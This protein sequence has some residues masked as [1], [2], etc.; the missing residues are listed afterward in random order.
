MVY[1]QLFVS[2]CR[3]IDTELHIINLDFVNR[4]RRL[5]F[6]RPS[7]SSAI[8]RKGGP[9]RTLLDDVHNVRGAEMG[10]VDD[11]WTVLNIEPRRLIL[12]HDGEIL[13]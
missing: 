9:V 10:K 2:G 3:S 1:R 13:E 5:L 4:N 6:I 7:A 11:G 8:S 12:G